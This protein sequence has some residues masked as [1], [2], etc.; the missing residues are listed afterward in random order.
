MTMK[1]MKKVGVVRRRKKRRRVGACQLWDKVPISAGK[2][3]TT[4]DWVGLDKMMR[5][6]EW[7][8]NQTEKKDWVEVRLQLGLF[9]DDDGY[10]TDF[11]VPLP[12]GWNDL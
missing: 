7:V 6:D 5:Y 2:Y 11:Y 9:G 3:S 12:V 8:C 4:E 10:I 1:M